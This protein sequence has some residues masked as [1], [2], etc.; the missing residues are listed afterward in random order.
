MTHP[1]VFGQK[2]TPILR[3]SAW[4]THS[5]WPHIPNMTQYGSTPPPPGKSTI[6]PTVK[7]TAKP[8]IKPTIKITAKP[9]TK[10]KIKIT[11]KPTTK[12]ILPKDPK[13]GLFIKFHP[14]RPK[15]PK[16]PV[17]PRLRDAKGRFVSRRQSELIV[18]ENQKAQKPI[19]RP[20]Q[21]PPPL[22][23]Q[24]TKY[25]YPFNFDDDIFQSENESLGKF[26]IVSTCSVQNK[27]FKSFTNEFKVK[28]FKKFDDVKEIYHIFQ[29]LIKTVKRRQKLS[30]NDMLRLVIHNEELPNAISTKFD[31]VKISN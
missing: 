21:R 7:I 15:P 11:T 4:K 12:H 19:R 24:Q 31:K 17:L 27:K 14:D 5:F 25:D 28:I 10:P 22:P 30:N 2:L 26:K 13:T 29:E 3:F 9:A 18:Q 23:P 8:T 20:Q 16:Q 1:Q 6:K